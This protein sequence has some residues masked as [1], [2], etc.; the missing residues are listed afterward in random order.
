MAHQ[1]GHVRTVDAQF[2][3]WLSLSQG[4]LTLHLVLHWF[5]TMS[6]SARSRCKLGIRRFLNPL[7]VSPGFHM[8]HGEPFVNGCR[9]ERLALRLK[10]AEKLSE[11]CQGYET[12]KQSTSTQPAGNKHQA[13]TR[14]GFRLMPVSHWVAIR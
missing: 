5:K 2:T 4:S 10:G 9:A 11:G 6:F 7:A 1:A 14:L 3:L 8:A 13:H 12:A